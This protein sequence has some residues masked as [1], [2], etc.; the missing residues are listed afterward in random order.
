MNRRKAAMLAVLIVVGTGCPE[1][2]G[3]GGF[4]DQAVAKYIK[5]NLESEK[6]CADGKPAEWHCRGEGPAKKCRWECPE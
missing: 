1:Q 5:A 2:W 3:K 4:I 6:S